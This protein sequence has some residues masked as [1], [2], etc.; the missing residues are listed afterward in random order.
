MNSSTPKNSATGS[1]K[2]SLNNN[3]FQYIK[4][5]GGEEGHEDI[6]GPRPGIRI[7]YI[8]L[9]QGRSIFAHCESGLRLSKV[10]R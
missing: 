1:R 9:V 4:C 8:L 7:I 10:K 5:H 6:P 2:Y 3:Q